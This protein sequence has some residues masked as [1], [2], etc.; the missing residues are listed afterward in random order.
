MIWLTWRQFRIQAV[1]AAATLVAFAILFAATGP[2]LASLYA[3]SGISSC[4]SGSCA[5]LASSFLNQLNGT[6]T[7]AVLYNISVYAILLTPA[8]IGVFWGAPLIAREFETGT[9]R[10]AWNQSITSTRWLA[11]KLALVGLA[12]I[13][14]TEGLSLMQA[15]W[16]APIGRAVSLS[17]GNNLSMGRF[18][19]LVFATHGITPVGYAAFAFTLGVTTGTLIRRAIPAMAITL[20][21]FAAVQVTVPLWVR[22]NLIPPD[23]TISTLSSVQINAFQQNTNTFMLVVGNLA[24]E[25]DAWILSSK[26]V[27]AAGQ[28][29]SV[30][31][32]VCQSAGSQTA[33]MNCLASHG[34]REEIT[35]Q[36]VGRYWAFQWIETAIYLVLSL[37]L[38]GFCFWRLTR[39]RS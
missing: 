22:P 36:P 10:L 39:R 9:Y 29:T 32:G 27:D 30:T 35:Y 1:V 21:I 18:S 4:H 16:A 24:S 26:A 17:G 19:S 2:H 38:A 34:I 37:A 33:F 28:P 7:Y 20:V 14:V 5:I 3:A 31:P 12:A 25:P 15:W 23:R 6:R 13:V 8:I 11:V